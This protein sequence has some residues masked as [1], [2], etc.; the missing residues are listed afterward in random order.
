MVSSTSAF[1]R[2]T[3]NQRGRCYAAH[4]VVGFLM[5]YP[6]SGH[7]VPKY[8]EKKVPTSRERAAQ[9]LP[10]EADLVVDLLPPSYTQ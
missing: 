3:L 9:F 4:Q 8:C 7:P 2:M 10:P 5:R 1:E 6:K